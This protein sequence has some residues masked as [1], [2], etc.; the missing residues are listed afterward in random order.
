MRALTS[1][2]PVDASMTL[3][4]AYLLSGAS[5]YPSI[6]T[7]KERDAESGNDNFG[8]RYYASSMGRMLSPDP[9]QLY[10][11]N[12]ADPQSLN[13]YSY[14]RNNPLINTDPTGMDCVRDL[15]NGAFDTNVGDCDNTTEAKANAGH[16]IDCNGCTTNS[17]GGTLDPTT[18]TMYLTDANG[19]GIAGT[20]VSDWAAPKGV[21]TEIEVNGND[22]IVG[23]GGYG[24]AGFLNQVP[25]ANL[26][27]RNDLSVR[28]PNAPPPLPKL[29]GKDKWLCLFG[30]MTNEMMGGDSGPSDS[31]DTAPGKGGAEAIPFHTTTRGGKVVTRQ[32]GVNGSADAKAGAVVEGWN[33]FWAALACAA[34]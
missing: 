1:V 11:A 17:T 16:Y 29:K 28:D 33:D 22:Q 31:S 34:N 25:Y 9:S 18:G 4:L 13:L 5:A 21:S 6:S 24:A 26:P 19:N 2:R 12:P 32:M 30:P 7:G 8:A 14:G 27:L 23:G 3:P 15:G 10:F 20:N